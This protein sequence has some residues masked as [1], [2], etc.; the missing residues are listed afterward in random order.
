MI[1]IR[2]L[3]GPEDSGRSNSP[4]IGLLAKEGQMALK[5]II[6]GTDGSA[7]SLRAVEWAVREAALR[8]TALRI[9]AVPTLPPRMSG[10]Q[11][12]GRPDTVADVVHKTYLRALDSAADC[13]AELEP[14]VVLET[15]LLSGPP[16]QALAETAADA[17]MLVVGSR[18]AGAFAALV[19]G[20]V[21]RYVATHAGCPVVVAREES[22]AVHR[23]IVV[24]VGD[25]DQPEAPLRFA[26]EEAA[27]RKA[28]LLAVHAWSWVIPGTGPL[29]A[30]TAAERAAIDSSQMAA[31]TAARLEER[32]ATWREAFPEVQADTEVIHAHPGRLLAGASARADLVVLGRH[33]PGATSSGARSV[34]HAVLGHAHGPVAVVPGD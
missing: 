23:E 16:A 24:G 12:E 33:R 11:P 18:G 10:H 27:L 32:L 3:A 29:G 13:A 5:P 7:E 2:K 34:M 30:L 4:G 8:K 31:D 26:F 28:R 1:L 15:A 20:S 22:L 6:A 21:S 9:V 19:L 14:G 17:S 25:L